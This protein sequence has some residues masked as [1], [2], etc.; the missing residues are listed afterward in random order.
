M[1]VLVIDGKYGN[2]TNNIGIAWYGQIA[3]VI[4]TKWHK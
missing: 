1:I 4:G 2:F 3:L